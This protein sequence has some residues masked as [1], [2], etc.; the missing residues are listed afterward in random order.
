M[1][2][3]D[4]RENLVAYLDGE[5]E[6]AERESISSHLDSCEDCRRERE[7]LGSTGDLLAHLRGD[8]RT[9]PDLAS[10]VLEAARTIDPWCAHIRRELVAMLD[11]ELTD[12]ESRPVREH[13]DECEDC[14]YEADALE[15]TGAA[16]AAWP[17]PT[18]FPNLTDHVFA[19]MGKR[20]GGRLRRFLPLAAAAAVLLL[21]GLTAIILLRGDGRESGSGSDDAPPADV[22]LAMD[23]LDAETLDLLEEDPKLLELAEQIDWLDSVSDADL[24]LLASL[25]GQG[26]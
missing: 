11:G 20:P 8:E 15:R 3:A 24:A 21:A 12:V 6:A 22:L 16:L 13:L 4:V 5:L 7:T 2:C 26:K 25:D 17:V 14:R 18:D 23:L 10:R 9:V 1:R 19:A